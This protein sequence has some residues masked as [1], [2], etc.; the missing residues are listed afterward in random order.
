MKMP[1]LHPLPAYASGRNDLPS[2]KRQVPAGET[3]RVAPTM[4]SGWSLSVI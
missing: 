3:L 4:T 2:D 1:N